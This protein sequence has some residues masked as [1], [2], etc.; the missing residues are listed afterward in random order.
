MVGEPSWSPEPFL[1][2]LAAIAGCCGGAGWFPPADA[3]SA[4]ADPALA[5]PE[6]APVAVPLVEPAPA[7]AMPAAAPSMP[8]APTVR[9]VTA[10]PIIAAAVLPTSPLTMRLAIKGITAI[11]SE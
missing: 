1:P 3:V 8:A 2:E 6:E 10:V 4:R 5:V 9:A 7:A 11:A